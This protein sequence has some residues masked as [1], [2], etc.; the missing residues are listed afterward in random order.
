MNRSGPDLI[1]PK[2]IFANE[3]YEGELPKGSMIHAIL[4]I[5]SSLSPKCWK[6]RE[7]DSD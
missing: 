3:G 6:L 2:I 5:E 1:A 7:L 4:I